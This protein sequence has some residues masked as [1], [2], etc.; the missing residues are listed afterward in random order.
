MQ[1]YNPGVLT[2]IFKCLTDAGDLSLDFFVIS[3][4]CG[5]F[6]TL[7]A[8]PTLRKAACSR[9]FGVAEIHVRS[10]HIS[11]FDFNLI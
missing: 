4:V 5:L 6:E 7:G 1:L 10:F 2:S 3:D 8:D 9:M 11:E